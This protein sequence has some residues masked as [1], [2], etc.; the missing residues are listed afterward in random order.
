[1]FP[2][3]SDLSLASLFMFVILSTRYLI[4]SF[5]IYWLLW[6]RRPTTWESRRLH[7][8]DP[9]K[10]KMRSEIKWSL[11]SCVVF[12]PPS[13]FMI[14]MTKLGHTQVYMDPSAYG[15]FYL[16]ASLAIYLVIHDAY[17]Y[18]THRWLHLPGVYQRFHKTHH[19]S[20][21]PTPWTSFS[22]HPVES[23]IEALIIP[24]LVFIIPIHI[25]V[26]GLVL[27]LMTFFGVVNHVGYE[28]YPR[29]WMRGLWGDHFIS[30]THHTLHH[31]RFNCNYGLYFRFWDKVMNTDKMPDA[32]W[33][34][35]VTPPSPVSGRTTTSMPVR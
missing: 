9:R 33:T 28:V 10:S 6:M 23:I 27:T 2:S 7:D 31:H 14:E 32:S 19:E 3:L 25:G 1:M 26:L 24:V 30:P 35:Q 17:F 18:W 11:W 22:F 4:V 15:W 34:P 12:A 16:F 20:I 13:A 29:S 8:M 5:L 21:N